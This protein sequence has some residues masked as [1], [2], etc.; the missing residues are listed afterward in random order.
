VA[1]RAVVD[2][3]TDTVLIKCEYLQQQA[4]KNINRQCTAQ[5]TGKII[6]VHH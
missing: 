6:T 2:M 5:N 4:G 1:D 3:A